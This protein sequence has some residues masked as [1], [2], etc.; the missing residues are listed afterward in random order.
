MIERISYWFSG[1]YRFTAR[2][3]ELLLLTQPD[4]P[5]RLLSAFAKALTGFTITDALDLEEAEPPLT[6]DTLDQMNHY[7]PAVEV[8]RLFEKSDEKGLNSDRMELIKCLFHVLMRWRIGSETTVLP[9]EGYMHETVMLGIG[10][11]E[12][13]GPRE[14]LDGN[15]PVYLCEP[16]VV[17]CLSSIFEKHPWTMNHAWITDAVR[18]ACN[19]SSLG[20]VFEEAVLLVLLQEFGGK[21]RALSD[22]FH[23]N[24]PW[25]LR[26]VTLVSLKRGDNGLML[27]C[28][29][30][31]TSGS[32]DRLG[33]RAT[34][35]TDVLNWLNNPNG[36]CFIFPDTHM[37]PDLLFFLQDEE[38][39]ELILGAVQ[40]RIVQRLDTRAWLSTLD[41]VTLQYFYTSNMKNGRVPYAPAAYPGLLNDITD[42]LESILGSA[43]YKPVFD[44]YRKKLR[45][46]TVLD[47]QFASQPPRKTPKYLRIIATQEA[48][49]RWASECKGDVVV[50]RWGLVEEYLGSM[51]DVVM[52]GSLSVA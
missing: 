34:S 5:H 38:T 44:E 50:L 48:H 29:V 35:P 13:I 6:T 51:V 18:T 43:E 27:C 30:S 39:K 25:G 15:Y 17:L 12:K 26:K 36:K 33:F 20:F 8:G 40:A 21:L 16:L 23:C 7:I 19:G 2:L 47:Q 9:I 28:P 32:S 22:I 37:G 31:W 14:T 52:T 11:L 49:Q 46:S 42:V 4:S 45:S 1:R 24:Q 3:I 41:S 10:H